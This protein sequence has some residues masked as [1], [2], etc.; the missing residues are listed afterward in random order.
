VADDNYGADR[1][2][3]DVANHQL[4]VLH[5]DGLY[6]HLRYANGNRDIARVAVI[7]WPGGC[8]IT[9]DHGSYTFTGNQDMF[10]LFL[11]TSSA[12][13]N[14][15][16]WAERIRNDPATLRGF[17]SDKF[18]E[19]VLAA[20]EDA[21]G[22]YPMDQLRAAVEAEVLNDDLE[23]EAEAEARSTL[24]AFVFPDYLNTNVNAGNRFRFERSWEWDLTDWSWPYL[25]C[26]HA[27][28]LTARLWQAMSEPTAVAAATREEAAV[29]LR[30][31]TP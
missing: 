21:R 8:T 10:R 12:G 11:Q 29:W 28:L 15:G 9:G 7:T 26:C 4:T 5:H 24:D 22:R 27:V 30:A 20:V 31:V 2:K 13:I 18:R 16:Y 6:R 23:A 17:S 19:H 3:V 25:W 1:F 14:P